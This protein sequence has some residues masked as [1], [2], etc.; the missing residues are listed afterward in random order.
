MA[1]KSD[2]K[3]MQKAFANSKGQFRAKAR[4]SGKSTGAYAQQMKNAG[5]KTGRQANLALMGMRY[6]G[7]RGSKRR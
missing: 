4:K 7:K 3:W 5:G 6:G 2:S 1:K